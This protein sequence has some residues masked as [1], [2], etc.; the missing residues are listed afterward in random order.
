MKSLSF[1]SGT[2]VKGLLPIL[3]FSSNDWGE[4]CFLP[5]L[6]QSATDDP[7]SIFSSLPYASAEMEH[8]ASPLRKAGAVGPSS[9]EHQWTRRLRF[10]RPV[11][12][13]PISPL[14]QKKINS[15][16]FPSNDSTELMEGSYLNYSPLPSLVV[17]RSVSPPFPL[18]IMGKEEPRISP[19]GGGTRPTF[20][21]PS[22]LIDAETGSLLF[23]PLHLRTDLPFLSWC[24]ISIR[25]P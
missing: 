9:L 19:N 22:L 2:K 8:S 3:F 23:F 11:G 6:E 14:P 15:G 5:R 16:L 1:P 18:P 4:H 13:M 12:V 20:S 24:S 25:P 7:A 21:P 10:I 17:G